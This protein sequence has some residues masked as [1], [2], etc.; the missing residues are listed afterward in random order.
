MT[1]VRPASGTASLAR[2]LVRDWLARATARPSSAGAPQLVGLTGA[3]IGRRYVLI[4]RA[5]VATEE[6]SRGFC[7][8]RAPTCDIVIVDPD[9]SRTHARV[10]RR[11]DKFF[12][13][14]LGS[15]NGTRVAGAQIPTGT[16]V[17]LR[18]GDDIE[19]GGCRLRFEHRAGRLAGLLAGAGANSPATAAHRRP[20]ATPGSGATA[21]RRAFA[22]PLLAQLLAGSIAALAGAGLLAV[23]LAI[24]RAM[25]W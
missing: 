11:G 8:G 14:D 4:A 10:T 16:P 15:K 2:A 19:L 23:C 24:F 6:P 1:E 21:G 18:D 17:L 20:V 25:F 22:S 7:I 3:V 9:L 12:L 5:D 13:R